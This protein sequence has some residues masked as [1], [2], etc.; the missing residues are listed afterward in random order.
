[1]ALASPAFQFSPF[2]IPPAFTAAV[3]LLCAVRIL[4]SRFSRTILT[5][6]LSAMLAACWQASIALSYLTSD[7]PT[8]AIL[9]RV[10]YACMSLVAPA[11]FQFAAT[12]LPRSVSR[13]IAARLA[14]LV[15]SQIG[16]LALVTDLLVTGVQRFHWGFTASYNPVIRVP[17]VI[18]FIGL[19]SAAM[20]EIYRGYPA[21]RMPDRKRILLFGGALSISAL[22]V[23][24][25][26]PAF[27]VDVYPCGWA[28]LLAS[29]GLGV[30]TLRR[31][32]M[33]PLTPSL[34]A[35]EIISTMRDLLLVSDH[36]GRIQFANNAAYAFL[37][38]GMDEIIGRKLDE[39]L[40][41]TAD[42]AESLQGR[43]MRDREYVFRTRMGQPIELTLSHSPIVH[44][45]ETT[46]AVIIG[47]DLRE[48]KR[49]EW[50]AR[51]AVTLLQSTL[52]STADGILVIG[53]GGRLLTWNQRF[54]DMWGIPA[55]IMEQEDHDVIGQLV[56]QLRDPA[57]F[58]RGLDE[59]RDH[60]EVES[61]HLLEF[62]DGRRLEQHSISR[63]LDNAPLRVWSFRDVTARLA[64]E[65]AL[66]DSET[67]YRLL[68]EQNAAGVCL[69]TLN[70]SILDCN[71]T[72]AEMAGFA[73]SELTGRDLQDL[74]E[75]SSTATDIAQL[76]GETPTLRGKEIELM[77]PDGTAVSA[78]ANISLLGQGERALVHMT[79][80]DISDRKRA[81]E[82][83]EFHAYHDALTQLPNRRLFV[84]RLEMNLLTARRAR[85][86][87]AVLF[88]DLDRFKIINDTLGHAVA[89][90]LLVE[91]A[92]RLRLCVRQTD[93]VARYGGDEFT[94]ILTDLHQPEDAARV[95]EKIL[96]A[97]AEPVSAGTT[98]VVVSVSIGIA[99]YPYDG[100]DLDTLLR[101][102]DD[103]MYRAKKAGRNTY[104]LCTEQM[105]TRAIE[106][107][108]MQSRLRRALSDN[109]L[110]LA[111]QP[112]V[113]L[114]T[115][116][117]IGA[118]VV[119][120]WNDPERG[121]IEPADFLPIAEDTGLIIPI[122]EWAL[123]A[124]CRQLRHW[125]DD[126][127]PP[128]RIAVNISDRQFQQRDFVTLV[129]RAMEQ[130]EIE[131]G[132][133]ELE[134]PAAAAMRDVELTIELLKIL[135]QSGVSLAV[136]DFGSGPSSLGYL[137][138]L[139]LD[140]VKIDR[141]FIRGVTNRAA[142]AAIAGAIIDVSRT[143]HLRVGADGVE[144]REQLE[145]LHARGCQEAQGPWFSPPIDPLSL[146]MLMKD[147]GS[148]PSVAQGTMPDADQ[149]S[150]A[151]HFPVG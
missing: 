48:R 40:V 145:V 105:K 35:N 132:L 113:S 80:V 45:G 24:D 27:G 2:A 146:G 8:A 137:Q 122:G 29:A 134:I 22:A 67:R 38:Y 93:T 9:S 126:G 50:E 148:G 131:P 76:L 11:V 16:M 25:F 139:P 62:K 65:E 135:R 85:G 15:A 98:T 97:I 37:G 13:R 55:T 6:L 1:M 71:A 83:I 51:R 89:D 151:P 31:Y 79:A 81:E 90:A 150:D 14:W 114:V 64:A 112:Q 147:P 92:Q 141:R 18:F 28:A 136:D 5:I 47:R 82:Q 121:M 107:L 109:E 140:S 46:G 63:E 106:R 21:S 75:H 124:A 110:V 91:M 49:F 87:M 57:E 99:V 100:A 26:L 116:L 69:T 32:G 12:I 125:L 17:F 60:P 119:V 30:Y 115:G 138:L 61:V 34:P 56:G 33:V 68:F 3:M 103:A 111:Y 143:L 77:R 96:E 52:D 73:A 104:Q 41:P 102:A 129:R 108:S 123:F 144:T 127:L 39:L 36:E 118:E 23:V 19:P 84:E 117:L 130:S 101:N 86:N 53:Q 72:F 128:L 42:S 133:L 149:S 120:R 78:L 88:V 7:A 74:F 43:W 4:L 10:A 95:A 70:G 94:L 58:L 66:R 44:E 54:V 142:D 59:L 20:I